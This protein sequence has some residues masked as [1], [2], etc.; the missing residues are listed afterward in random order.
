M[1]YLPVSIKSKGRVCLVVGGGEVAKRKI[2]L[3]SRFGC[4]LRIVSP[5][6]LPEILAA[7]NNNQ[8]VILQRAFIES[9]LDG[10]ELVVA[11][12]DDAK[13]NLH[14]SVLC[15][16]RNILVNVVDQPELCSFIFPSI[17][18]RDPITIAV[19]SNGSFPLLARHLRYQLEVMIPRNIGQLAKILAKVRATIKARI[20]N[21]RQRRHFLESLINKI[22]PG[23]NNQFDESTVLSLLDAQND[24]TS[25]TSP[26]IVYLVGAGPGDPDLLT[27]KALRLIQQADIVYYDRLVSNEIL[28]LVRKDAKLIYAGKSQSNHTIPQENLNQLLIAAA[29]EG[30]KVVRLKGGDPFIFGRGGEEIYELAKAG[31]PFQIVPGITA[32]NGCAAYAGIPLTHRDHAQ[33]V[34]FLTGH[35]KEGSID[36]NWIL[37]QDPNTT[38]VFYMSLTGIIDIC[39]K[40]TSHGRNPNTPIALIENGTTEKQKVYTST[41]LELPNLIRR[42]QIKPPTLAIIGSVVNLREELNWPSI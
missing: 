1:N 4:S 16:S 7:I 13:T 10:A 20:D 39:Q 3:L 6:L 40:L 15:Q 2:D 23:L 9:D 33:S 18:E 36:I 34:L 35:K 8:A 28:Q 22:H 42:T 11:A 29:N 38:L 41:L 30:N 25:M 12:T 31:V 24:I 26:G 32:A 27:L 17:V 37:L 21:P 19:S 14:V 5:D